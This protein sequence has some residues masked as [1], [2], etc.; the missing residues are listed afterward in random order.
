MS[1]NNTDIQ[2]AL[3]IRRVVAKYFENSDETKIQAKELMDEFI[4]QGIF[5]KNYKDGKPIRDF[6]RFLDE[7]NHLHLIPQ[8]IYEQKEMNKNW[9]FIKIDL[10]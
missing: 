2:K 8:V 1:I 4:E 5:N 7:N 3:R 6:L 10:K 9:Y